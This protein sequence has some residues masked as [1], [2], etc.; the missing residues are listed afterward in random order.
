MMYLCI[1]LVSLSFYEFVSMNLFRTFLVGSVCLAILLIQDVFVYRPF[2]SYLYSIPFMTICVSQILQIK[3]EEYLKEWGGLLC[4]TPAFGYTAS[5]YAI[6]VHDIQ[7]LAL[8]QGAAHLLRIFFDGTNGVFLLFLCCGI[9]AR[10]VGSRMVSSLFGLI[11][12]L[13]GFIKGF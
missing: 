7:Y 1:Y 3:Q 2:S 4:M 6:A 12:I 13:Q 10:V 5:K 9:C 11:G 8:Q